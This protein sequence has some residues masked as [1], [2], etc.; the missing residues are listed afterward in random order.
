MT[1]GE[2]IYKEEARIYQ[3]QFDL[4]LAKYGEETARAANYG[5]G[6]SADES[7]ISVATKVYGIGADGGAVVLV[8]EWKP[9]HPTSHRW[10]PYESTEQAKAA[11]MT[12][13]KRMF[14]EERYRKPILKVLTAAYPDTLDIPEIAEAV[15]IS[16]PHGIVPLS[17]L[18]KDGLIEKAS[19]GCWRV[20]PKVAK[21]TW[22]ELCRA[23]KTGAT[24]GKVTATVISRTEDRDKTGAIVILSDSNGDHFG[25][26]LSPEGL[27]Q[28]RDMLVTN[29]AVLLMLEAELEGDDNIRARLLHAEPLV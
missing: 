23:V 28:Y 22:A 29:A 16:N 8:S 18:E 17:G 10:E 3:E 5:W 12:E 14:E 11:V 25:V 9:P 26:E 24:A 6:V 7:A 2:R 15:G 27:A 20:T 13:E 1:E 4:I 19:N 21:A